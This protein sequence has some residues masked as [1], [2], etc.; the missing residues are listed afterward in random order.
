MQGGLIRRLSTTQEEGG[1][2][3]HASCKR[4]SR[5]LTSPDHLSSRSLSTLEGFLWLGQGP[6]EKDP[7]RYPRYI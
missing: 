6:K 7:F 1:L 2:K 4:N 5:A 3:L